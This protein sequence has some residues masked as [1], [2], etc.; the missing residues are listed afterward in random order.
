MSRSIWFL[1]NRMTIKASAEDTGGAYALVESLIR[2][3]FSPPLHI[4]HTEEEAF[5]VL[6]GR[7]TFRL[8]DET[9]AAEPGSYVLIPRGAPHTFLVEGDEPARM[10]T[11]IS[12][13]GG[14][15]FFAEVGRP[16]EAEGLPPVEPVDAER[17]RRIAAKFGSE[18][19]GPPLVASRV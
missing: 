12:P 8:G 16:A 5:Y 7:V 2:P 17:L 13:G 6:E 19:I 1:N 15:E 14:E 9:I 4:Q 3:G 18:I 10:L 11:M